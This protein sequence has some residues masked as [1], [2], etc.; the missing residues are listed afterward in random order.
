MSGDR[1][2]IEHRPVNWKGRFQ[3]SIDQTGPFSKPEITHASKQAAMHR[4]ATKGADCQFHFHGERKN[5]INSTIF[6]LILFGGDSY[7]DEL[8]LCGGEGGPLI[9]TTLV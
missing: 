4:N 9:V 3:V 8:S 2:Q 1:I 5:L 6:G 7:P